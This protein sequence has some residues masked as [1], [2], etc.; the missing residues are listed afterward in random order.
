MKASWNRRCMFLRYL[1]R[2]VLNSG[3]EKD[4]ILFFLYILHPFHHSRMGD[5]EIVENDSIN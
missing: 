1:A 2:I 3:V 5:S 4:C